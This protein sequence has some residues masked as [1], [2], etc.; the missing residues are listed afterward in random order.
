VASDGR[1]PCCRSQPTNG[2]MAITRKAAIATGARIG[3]A[4]LSAARM[5]MADATAASVRCSD[6]LRLLST[7][8]L[9]DSAGCLHAGPS[10]CAGGT[11]GGRKRS[12]LRCPC[13]RA[14]PLWIDGRAVAAPDTTRLR[15]RSLHDQP[16]PEAPDRG[17]GR[18]AAAPAVARPAATRAP[19]PDRDAA[20]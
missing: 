9:L 7:E 14:R 4:A 16:S 5:M 1:T 15:W 6:A 18:A 13:L 12:A 20:E 2:A 19:R 3:A 10:A 11:H 17:R 8:P